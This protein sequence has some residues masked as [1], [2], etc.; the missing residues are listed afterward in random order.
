VALVFA[1]SHSLAGGVI[2]GH[3]GAHS[4]W[5]GFVMLVVAPCVGRELARPIQHWGVLTVVLGACWMRAGA[6]P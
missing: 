1:C 2:Q 5:E 4:S 6:A 3:G